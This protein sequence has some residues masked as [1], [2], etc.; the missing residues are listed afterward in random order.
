MRDA[1]GKVNRIPHFHGENLP[2]DLDFPPPREDEDHFFTFRVYV[3]R[4]T[5]GSRKDVRNS[6]GNPLRPNRF[7]AD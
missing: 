1:R 4:G 2:P 5:E 7:P 3:P 6:Q